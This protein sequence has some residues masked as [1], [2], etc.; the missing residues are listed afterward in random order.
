[1]YIGN[2]VREEKDR[3]ME[4]L[5]KQLVDVKSAAISAAEIAAKNLEDLSDEHS[6]QIQALR[7]EHNDRIAHLKSQHD[8]QLK[9]SSA[10]HAAEREVIESKHRQTLDAMREEKKRE[11]DKKSIEIQEVRVFLEQRIAALQVGLG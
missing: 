10:T 8:A 6:K 5:D 3:L 9:E 4:Q 7:A 2:A 1:M 11:I